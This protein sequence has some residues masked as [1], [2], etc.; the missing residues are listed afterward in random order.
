MIRSSSRLT[1]PAGSIA[2]T[3]WDRADA[4]A[5]VLIGALIL[6]R[7]WKLLRETVDVLMEATPKGVDLT[8]VRAHILDVPHVHAV[9]DLQRQFRGLRPA[10]AHRARRRGRLLL[11]RRAPAPAAGPAAAA[12]AIYHGM[13]IDSVSD[14]DL[15]YTTPLGSPWDAVQMAA[16]AWVRETRPR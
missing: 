7:T 10:S 5:S 16:Q 8:H 6:P 4:V 3:G 9:H 1:S 13:T 14:L 15:S 12:T 11:P 2:V